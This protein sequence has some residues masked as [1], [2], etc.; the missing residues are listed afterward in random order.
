MFT[1]NQLTMT[2]QCVV[3]KC[4]IALALM[5]MFGFCNA[6]GG[7]LTTFLNRVRIPLSPHDEGVGIGVGSQPSLALRF[8]SNLTRY[9]H[10]PSMSY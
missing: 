6:L 8:R 2:G 10:V 5:E 9:K 1:T 3:H 4:F 7:A